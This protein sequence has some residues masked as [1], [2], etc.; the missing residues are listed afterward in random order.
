MSLFAS[1]GV[2]P[3]A[4]AVYLQMVNSGVASAASLAAA[5]GLPESEVSA[6]LATLADLGLTAPD[7]SEHGFRIVPPHTAVE[8]LIGRQEEEL[9]RR[10]AEL[11]LSREAATP[12]LDDYVRAR[13]Q[14]HSDLVE[15]IDDPTVVRA[16]LRQLVHQASEALWTTHQG[17]ALSESAT[18]DSL[19]LDREL[20]ARGVVSR[21][22]FP[23]DSLGPRH[24]NDYLEKTAE[25]GHRVRIMSSVPVLTVIVDS[26]VG[27]VPH[28]GR[29]GTGAHVLHGEALV[30]PLVILFEQLW[31]SAVPFGSTD[32]AQ[33]G[34]T[35]ENR[36]RLV[37]VLMAGGMKDEA[38]ARRMD[39]STRTVRRLVSALLEQ[40]GA[41]SRFQ[42]GVMAARLGW[43]TPGE[44]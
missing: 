12:L 9:E 19:A 31:L 23:R 39:I 33:P 10:R 22:I 29:D 5:L 8:I 28:Q 44:E 17:P 25:L 37:A 1:L 16:R 4:E 27:L 14:Q 26:K 11:V 3:T 36:L 13:V 7:P 20:A 41:E 15:L 24:W 6:A 18:A 34:D 32:V 43:L 30:K 35:P 40:L 42:A 21:N 2:D 38:I